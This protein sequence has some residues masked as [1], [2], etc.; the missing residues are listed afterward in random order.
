MRKEKIFIRIAKNLKHIK[1]KS[2]I[3]VCGNKISS[4]TLFN[5]HNLNVYTNDEMGYT[6]MNRL[7]KSEVLYCLLQKISIQRR[8]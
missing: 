8:R 3:S 5:K 7:I 1:K 2:Y 4:H 6:G